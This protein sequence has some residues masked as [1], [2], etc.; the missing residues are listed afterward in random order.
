MSAAAVHRIARA[1]S[2]LVMTQPFWGCLALQLEIVR[3]D[4]FETMATDGANLFYNAEFVLSLAEPELIGV[5]AHE[6]EHVARLHHTRR[7]KRDMET[8]NRA[9][10]LAINP[11]LLSGGFRLP[12]GAFNEARFAGQSAE[13]IFATLEKEKPASP[14][15][16]AAGA[17]GAPD[18]G[19]SGGIIDA[20]GADNEGK[21]ADIEAEMQARV[22]QAAMV[23]KA[24]GAGK[25]PAGILETL[26]TLDAPRVNWRDEMRRFADDSTHKDSSWTRPNRRYVASGLILPGA[27]SIAPAHIVCVIDT[28]GSMDS[29]ALSAI[30]GEL[31]SI[32]DEGATDRITIVQCDTA[33]KA[34][35]AYEAGDTLALDIVG[36]GGTAFA[37]AFKWIDENASDASAIVYLTDLDCSDFG[38]APSAPVLWAR[39]GKPRPAPWGEIIEVDP[40]A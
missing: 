29:R 36:R 13:S 22:R 16:P 20:P 1:R 27:V 8:W 15:K 14:P 10:D 18:P 9:C 12:K 7:G 39:Y 26:A 17:G 6:V 21:R 40:N 4:E 23:A 28:S 35:A 25:L 32:L 38:P 11:G 33:V 24:Q 19:K 37:P 3:R 31:Q 34:S 2:A 5:I 30:G